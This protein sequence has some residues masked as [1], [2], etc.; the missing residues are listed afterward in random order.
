MIQSI[1]YNLEK[2]AD[3]YR[4]Q[5]LTAQE[6]SY[7]VSIDACTTSPQ[8]VVAGIIAN[9]DTVVIK[10][11]TDGKYK[12]IVS[13][14]LIKQPTVIIN[15]FPYLRSVIVKQIHNLLCNNCG[16]KDT[17][18]STNCLEN[19][20]NICKE[21][22][23]LQSNLHIYNKLINPSLAT[24]NNQSLIVDSLIWGYLETNVC[25]YHSRLCESYTSL[26]LT[27]KQILDDK[28]LKEFIGINYL[29]LRYYELLESTSFVHAN[30]IDEV[31][32]Y[33]YIKACLSKLGIDI[34]V[35][36]E[37]ATSRY[38]QIRQENLPPT[39]QGFDVDFAVDESNLYTHVFAIRNFI[40]G[41]FDPN[42]DFYSD[43]T[44]ETEP[45]VGKLY[46]NNVEQFAYPFTINASQVTNLRYEATFLQQVTTLNVDFF[47]F[48]I[49][50]DND[51][52]LKSNLAQIQFNL[53]AAIVEKPSCV[54]DVTYNISFGTDV[55]LQYQDFINA[56]IH[57]DGNS[58]SQLKIVTSNLLPI[59]LKLNG[60]PLIGT[61]IINF[62]DVING[63]LT[64]TLM[65]NI[66]VGSS[67]RFSYAA[68]DT[69]SEQFQ[70]N[71]KGVEISVMDNFSRTITIT[72]EQLDA[73]TSCTGATLEERLTKYINRL[74]YNKT[75]TDA[76]VWINYID[77]TEI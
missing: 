20:Y 57:P 40:N 32:N 45:L 41:F 11:P 53:R 50:D 56:F 18:S 43:I 8:E 62:T 67:Y 75:S 26:S 12:L 31:Y 58:I 73:C 21:L 19:N 60:V 4:I 44:I 22:T 17:A 64:A 72:S 38:V 35:F 48:R 9:N 77:N 2:I 66:A 29:A 59:Q 70:D 65:N 49:S 16:C 34:S 23:T 47:N 63:L 39:V 10:L 76:D 6:L 54:T 36:N 51:L 71:C 69:V 33:K 42:G 14:D 13:L 37:I 24:N 68:S 46:L 15:H 27:G 1:L 52:P 3:E 25:L 7:T 28:I 55:V 5:S 74:G 30:Y 61:Q